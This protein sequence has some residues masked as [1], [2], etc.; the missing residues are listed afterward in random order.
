MA[1]KRLAVQSRLSPPIVLEFMTYKVRF[2]KDLSKRQMLVCS[3]DFGENKERAI[4]LAGGA[5]R[6]FVTNMGVT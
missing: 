2:S 3:L 6:H 5:Y 4:T 1:F